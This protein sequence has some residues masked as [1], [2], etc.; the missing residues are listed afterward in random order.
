SRGFRSTNR[1]NGYAQLIR[2]HLRAGLR[3]GDPSRGTAVGAPR[4]PHASV[5]GR[6]TRASALPGSEPHLSTGCDGR[7]RLLGER[8]SGA[9]DNRRRRTGTDAVL[10][11]RPAGPT[12]HPAVG[13]TNQFRRKLRCRRTTPR[14]PIPGRSVGAAA[15]SPTRTD[16]SVRQAPDRRPV[17]ALH[18]QP[19]VPA[20]RW[21]SPGVADA[22]PARCRVRGKRFRMRGGSHASRSAGCASNDQRYGERVISPQMC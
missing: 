14:Y 11:R 10:R 22:G 3:P 8:N 13:A 18:P 1:L 17:A 16:T 21:A 19:R 6:R 15:L 9:H 4:S 2:R 12:P 20:R 7:D 5:P